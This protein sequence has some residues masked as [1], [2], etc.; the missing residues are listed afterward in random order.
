MSDSPVQIDE[1]NK[2]KIKPELMI[3]EN[4]YPVIFENQLF[5]FFK[6]ENELINCYEVT[7]KELV[8]KAQKNPEKILELLEEWNK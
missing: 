7:D 2:I 5:L 6:D 8:E 3:T 1:D 4:L